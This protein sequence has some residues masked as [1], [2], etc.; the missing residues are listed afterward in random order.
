MKSMIAAVVGIAGL[1]A[2]ANAAWGL[3]FEVF[4]NVSA[5]WKSSVNANPGDIVK[6]RFGAY[7]D[8]GT[9]VTTGDG[10][11]N[12][13]AL[14]RFTGSNQITNLGAGDVIQNLV[15]TSSSGNPALTQVAGNTIG[16]TAVTSFGGQLLLNLPAAAETYYQI[17]TGEVKVVSGTVRSMVFQNKT[18]GSGN[19]KGLT[20]YHDASPS[21]KQS[22][23]PDDTAGRFDLTA[24]INVV[25]TP[26]SMALI[27]LGG[28][29]AARRRRA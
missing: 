16:T 15:R 4:D 22:A 8:V 7:F 29:V 9:K 26:A 1:A 11:G 5:S 28:L 10:T 25:P 6:I 24:S 27:G 13:V 20:F 3:K 14:N 2:A 21:N 19:T 12:A 18:F 23:A 17:F